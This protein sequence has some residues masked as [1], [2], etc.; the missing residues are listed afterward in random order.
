MELLHPG[1]YL[2]EV[3]S[4]VRPIE[5]VSTSTAAF[6]G[7]A[8]MGSLDTAV[9][10]TTMTEFSSRYGGFLTDGSGFLAHSVLQFFQ[11]GG[12]RAYIARIAGNGA[13]P[14]SITVRP[15]SAAENF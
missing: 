8:E 13:A 14:A 12:K 1:V 9:L 5:G 11:N 4:G 6:I 15:S 7:K 3:P 10:V 2:Q